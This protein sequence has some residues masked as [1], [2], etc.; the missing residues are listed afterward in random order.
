MQAEFLFTAEVLSLLLG[1]YTYYLPQKEKEN[2]K[3][4][5]WVSIDKKNFKRTLVKSV[6][7]GTFPDIIIL[8]ISKNIFM[9]RQ[10]TEK[11]Y[12]LDQSLVSWPWLFIC[13]MKVLKQ[14]FTPVI[15]LSFL[16]ML[17]FC[18]WP[19]G[20]QRKGLSIETCFPLLIWNSV[21]KNNHRE[22]RF[23]LKRQ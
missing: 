21:V 18:V 22:S 13:K 23:F 14:F 17:L 12:S 5:C 9:Y 1:N 4:R 11:M 8:K 3:K 7:G 2:W 15:I 10:F 20:G 19:L 6:L 16:Y